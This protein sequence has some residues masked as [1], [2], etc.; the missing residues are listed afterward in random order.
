VYEVR[1]APSE[2][3][4]Y[5]FSGFTEHFHPDCTLPYLLEDGNGYAFRHLTE[6]LWKNWYNETPDMHYE[7]DEDGYVTCSYRITEEGE[8]TAITHY[9][10]AQKRN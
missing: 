1:K 9:E 2:E 6:P 5:S 4:V 10:Y 7:Y 8:R 3:L